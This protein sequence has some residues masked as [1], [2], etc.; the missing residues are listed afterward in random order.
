MPINSTNLDK[1]HSHISDEASPSRVN[2]IREGTL[3]SFR[4]PPQRVSV[5]ITHAAPR[6]RYATI[7]GKK[8]LFP[9]QIDR[10]RN[11][12]FSALQ[13]IEAIPIVLSLVYQD[14]KGKILDLVEQ[15]RQET[16][17][18]GAGAVM[19][20]FLGI[21]RY[22]D[23]EQ[24]LNRVETILSPENRML[25]NWFGQCELA[26]A[27]ELVI[28]LN[29]HLK[30]T[31]IGLEVK[32]KYYKEVA[33]DKAGDLGWIDTE[34][35]DDEMDFLMGTNKKP[36]EKRPTAQNT[37]ENQKLNEALFKDIA[38]ILERSSHSAIL[39]ITHPKLAGHWVVVD[40][41]N[42]DENQVTIRDPYSAYAY[43]FSLEELSDM[44]PPDDGRVSLV[45]IG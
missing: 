45:Y 37:I 44:L 31:T 26:D 34:D 35:S 17:S 2:Q 15:P 25:W 18:C 6:R 5:A 39:S 11:Q 1:E 8:D 20:L 12:S 3:A 23:T 41:L 10:Q 40:E 4:T 21:V 9:G 36:L 28:A 30:L 32:A 29:S 43:R 27:D 22:A 42:I 16:T 38:S 7:E 14:S 33:T 13:A 19:M 24:Y